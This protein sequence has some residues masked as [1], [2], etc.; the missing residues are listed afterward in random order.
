MVVSP[1]PKM[2]MIPVLRRSCAEMEKEM[3]LPFMI[4]ASMGITNH[5]HG[6]GTV[7]VNRSCDQRCDAE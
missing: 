7:S 6:V 3:C 4:A 2:A 1:L 5:G